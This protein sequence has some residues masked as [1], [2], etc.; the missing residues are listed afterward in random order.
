[1]KKI[2]VL[3]MVLLLTTAC[4]ERVK[5]EDINFIDF[6]SFKIDMSAYKDMTSLDHNFKGVSPEEF[7]R[8]FKEGG[9]GAFL[10]GY[11]GCYN[12]QQSIS[13]LNAAAEKVGVT[14]YYMD[15]Y[16]EKYPL[17]LYESDMIKLLEPYLTTNEKGQKAIYT[18]HLIILVNGEVYD[19]KIGLFKG[20]EKKIIKEYKKMLDVFE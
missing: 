5:K 10:L 17:E 8:V 13:H 2:I 19:S 7:M 20:K 11:E 6:D 9:S 3:I 4:G 14:V 16:S 12:C 18:P 1:M 15:C